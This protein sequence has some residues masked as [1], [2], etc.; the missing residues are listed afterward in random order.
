MSI[1]QRLH[2]YGEILDGKRPEFGRKRELSW[3][4]LGGV[5]TAVGLLGVMVVVR[6]F[7]GRGGSETAIA[8]GSGAIP[9]EVVPGRIV[10]PLARTRITLTGGVEDQEL[11]FDSLFENDQVVA[12][13]SG[14]VVD[15]RQPNEQRVSAP[16]GLIVLRDRDGVS[17]HYR[18]V[19]PFRGVKV[20]SLVTT[21][22]PIAVPTA[23]GGQRWMAISVR[24]RSGL[25]DQHA[26]RALLS[27]SVP[28]TEIRNIRVSLH[29]APDLERMLIAAQAAGFEFAGSG[30]R[31]STGQV[32]V[33]KRNCGKS[34]YDIWFKPAS[35]CNPPTAKPGRSLHELGLA[36]DFTIEGRAIRAGDPAHRWLVSNASQFGFASKV[37]E[38]WHW[39][40]TFLK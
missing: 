18:H 24:D 21:S 13:R 33:R 30:Y 37:D 12:M 9:D 34:D 25:V 4:R 39:E 38:P 27:L 11:R 3:I 17:Y 19:T 40:Y 15:V 1:E 36:I 35:D 29:V 20:G 7:A 16:D 2:S 32:A 5:A 6:D 28:I 8:V 23:E 14:A 31:S 22:L 10:P 26:L